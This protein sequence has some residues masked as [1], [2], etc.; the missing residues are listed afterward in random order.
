MLLTS[1]RQ[2]TSF[3]KLKCFAAHWE[4]L[5]CSYRRSPVQIT[6]FFCWCLLWRF[7]CSCNLEIRKYGFSTNVTAAMLCFYVMEVVRM[8][9]MMMIMARHT[10]VEFIRLIATVGDEVTASSHVDAL[11]IVALPL[12]AWSTCSDIHQHTVHTAT[13]TYYMYSPRQ[14]TSSLSSHGRSLI[15]WTWI[16]V[17]FAF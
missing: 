17:G 15:H 9:M 11:T 4:T 13:S 10:A 16:S 3:P 6:K 8:M 5:H 2:P 7:R 14:L 12:R 1:L